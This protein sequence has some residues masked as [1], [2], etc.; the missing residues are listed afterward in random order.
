MKR[1]ICILILIAISLSTLSLPLS[2]VSGSDE[3]KT[4]VETTAETLKDSLSFKSVYD[5]QNKRVNIS[6]TLGSDVFS[7]HSGWT[8]VAYAVPPGSSEYD[9]VNDPEAKPLAEVSVSIN[10]EFSFKADTTLDRYSRY[11]IFLRSPE[12]EFILTTEA[13]YP[14]VVSTYEPNN[15]RSTYKGIATSF[16][17]QFSELGAGSAIVPIYW[18]KLFSD[19]SSI[20]FFIADGKQY[21]FNKSVIDELDVSIRSMNISGSRVYLRLLKSPTSDNADSEYLMPDV[22]DRDTV[23]KIH[24]AVSF[25]T[26]RYSDTVSGKFSGIILGKGWDQPQKYNFCNDASLDEYIDRCGVYTVIVANAARSID[27]SIDVV[28]PLTAD[29]F[30]YRADN[31]NY[32]GRF[33]EGLLSYFDNSFYSG[34]KCSFLLDVSAS[35]LNI[36][37]DSSINGVDLKYTD[38]EGKISAGAQNSFTNYLEELTTKYDSCPAKYIFSWTPQK[39][40]RGNALAAAYVYSYYAL[41]SDPYV[42]CFTVD[43]LGKDAN[44]NVRDILYVIKHIDTTDTTAATKNLAAFFGKENWGEILRSSVIAES[45]VK[46]YYSSQPQISN[47]DRFVGEFSYF[48][49]SKSNLFENWYLG[50][51]TRNIRIDYRDNSQ[52]SL[53]ADLM[54]DENS[55]GSELLYIYEYP[56]NMIYTPNLRFRFHISDAYENTLYEVRFTLENSSNRYESIAIVEGDVANDIT[57]DISKFVK[58]N[59]IRSIRISIRSLDGVANECGFWLY[60]VTGMSSSYSSS[61]LNSIINSERDKIR[62]NDSTRKEKNAF[63]NFAIALGII[64]AAGALGMG[65]FAVVRRD[66]K[67]SE[68]TESE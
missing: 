27:P 35:P 1:F 14:E 68:E 36:T 37:N 2:A 29:G 16:D 6:G 60:D 21:F 24:A 41:L 63:G 67:Y 5:A 53:H 13:Q 12:G 18:D 26:E 3:T 48:D 22:Y 11:A 58:S 46:H 59:S 15:N 4:S 52:K 31:G 61:Q 66:D 65:V 54:F 64:F 49:F 32:F 10:V 57:L 9:V 50:V 20:L 43:F 44:P 55:N 30:T 38:P 40:L 23:A 51:G 28:I 42:S 47:M 33:T 62:N 25:L 34:I 56:E 8:L 17:A 39:T 7:S 45:G 19:S